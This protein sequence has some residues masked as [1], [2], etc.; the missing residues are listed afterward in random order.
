[1]KWND[2]KINKTW[3]TQQT[4][5]QALFK[6]GMNAWLSHYS[7][8][9]QPLVTVME[10]EI[11]MNGWMSNVTYGN[12]PFN[13]IGQIHNNIIH[14]INFLMFEEHVM[15]SF[16][17]VKVLIGHEER[18]FCLADAGRRAQ[19]LWSGGVD[20]IDRHS[21]RPQEEHKGFFSGQWCS[22]RRFRSLQH[23]QTATRNTH[24]RLQLKHLVKF[25]IFLNQASNGNYPKWLGR[26][27]SSGNDIHVNLNV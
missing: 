1:M 27:V 6:N 9:T 15:I 5:E 14:H 12:I 21:N 11:W 19:G 18:S 23:W 2:E 3:D 7:S 16:V 25:I 24:H 17:L 13:S 26:D 20:T 4:G 10:L 8:T 22:L